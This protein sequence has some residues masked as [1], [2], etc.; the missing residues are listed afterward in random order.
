MAL[1]PCLMSKPAV[2]T[3]GLGRMQT[4]DVMNFDELPQPERRKLDL[5]H[6]SEAR[7]RFQRVHIHCRRAE[8][9]PSQANISYTFQ[10]DKKKGIMGPLG[11]RVLHCFCPWWR[12]F[13]R[14]LLH[15]IGC[16]YKPPAWAYG[17][18]KGRRREALMMIPRIVCWK[19]IQAKQSIAVKSYDMRSA[20]H[21]GSH[22][23]LEGVSHR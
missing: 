16:E 17:G 10:L 4:F 22:R 20:F 15:D 13:H 7:R 11:L 21:S 5:A 2:S 9:V 23:D 14:Y 8:M 19:A 1:S 6:C 18:I 12:Q 3:E